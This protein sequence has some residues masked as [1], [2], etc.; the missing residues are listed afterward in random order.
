MVKVWTA[1]EYISELNGLLPSNR[2]CI[3]LDDMLLADANLKTEKNNKEI[4]FNGRHYNIFFYTY[5]AISIRYFASFHVV[6]YYVFAFN[7]PALK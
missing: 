2:F 7:E 1:R 6:I 4:F 3:V 5:Y